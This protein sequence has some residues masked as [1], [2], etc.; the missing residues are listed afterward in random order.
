MRFQGTNNLGVRRHF[1]ITGI[2]M[3]IDKRKASENFVRK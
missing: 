3:A 2:S 1:Q